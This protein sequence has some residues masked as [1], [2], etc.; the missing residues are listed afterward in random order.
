MQHVLAQMLQVEEHTASGG[1]FAWASQLEVEG[2]TAERVGVDK[3]HCSQQLKVWQQP[4]ETAAPG[5]LQWQE[6]N[7][8][9]SPVTVMVSA[10]RPN[11]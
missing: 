10:A 11:S 4:Q 9:R 3:C 1:D 6:Q 7:E 8:S 2:D 5:V